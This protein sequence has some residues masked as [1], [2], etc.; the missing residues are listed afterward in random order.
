MSARFDALEEYVP[1]EQPRDRKYVKL[2]TNE[3][4]YPPSA[5]VLDAVSKA[6]ASLLNLYPDPTC[7]ELRTAIAGYYNVGMENVCVTNGSDEALSFAFMAYCDGN[8]GV[9]FPQISYGFYPVFAQLYSLDSLAI[10]LR[11]D[12]TVDHRDYMGIGR[13]VFIA[14]PNAPTGIA[15][16]LWQIEEILTSNEND[17]VVIDEA[18]VDF[19]ADSAVSLV[20]KYD[21]LLVIGT[22]S[23]SRSMAG[24]RLGFAIGQAHLIS[25][26]EKLRYST[27]PYN[28]N[29]LT[30]AAGTRA[31]ADH[32][33]YEENCRRV[34]QTRE[35]FSK[36]LDE[37]GFV[38]T[39]S[40]T[41]FVFARHPSV[42][43]E[44][45]FAA[46]RERGFL[47]RRFGT[48]RIKDYLRITVGT[49]EDMTSLAAVLKE[50][51]G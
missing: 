40:K 33:Y 19:G 30:L 9:A 43:G 4:P 48:E 50:I 1:G 8:K 17:V 3:S 39:D 51:V 42:P 38:R 5:G 32:E 34:A 44:K 36:R 41:N 46:L 10:P 31:V 13:T 47:V 18:Y 15:L 22:Y 25:D 12:L 7:K 49:A 28:I 35:E 16:E 21:N 6:E 2:N 26:L 14:N 37:M 23:K 45:L 27:N 24:A 29:R 11:D 20:D